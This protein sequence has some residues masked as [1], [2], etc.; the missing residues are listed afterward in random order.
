MRACISSWYGDTKTG[1]NVFG[2]N[3]P[4]AVLCSITSLQL[5]AHNWRYSLFALGLALWVDTEEL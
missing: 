3:L 5:V 4:T 1:Q 2:G